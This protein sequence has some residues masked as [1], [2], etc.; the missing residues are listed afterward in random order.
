MSEELTVA[1]PHDRDGPFTPQI[2]RKR[3]RRLSGVDE[4]VISLSA[5]GLTTREIQAHRR[6]TVPTFPGR[7]SPRLPTKLLRA[8]RNGRTGPW[9]WS[10]R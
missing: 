6:F 9:T 4:M 5:K 10:T 3:Q 8:W 7:R 1:V 2:V